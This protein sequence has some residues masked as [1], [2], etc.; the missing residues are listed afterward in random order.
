MEFSVV[1]IKPDGMRKKLVGE[2]ISRLERAKLNLVAIKMVQLTDEILH[3]WHAHHKDKPFFPDLVEFMK[4]TP[5]VAMIWEGENAVAKIRE[6]CG[7]TDPAKAA[8]GTIRAD[9][10]G[11]TVMENIIHASD[12]PETAEKEKNLIFKKEEIFK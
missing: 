8:P 11:P 12:S 7:A 4:K 2:I 3:P 1:L 5:V 10:G 9:F 6:L